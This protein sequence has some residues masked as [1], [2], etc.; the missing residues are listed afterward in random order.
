MD[1]IKQIDFDK[2]KSDLYI[3]SKKPGDFFYPL[4][5][6]GKKK[7]K[8]YFIDHKIPKED[9][10]RVT[11]LVDGDDIVCVLGMQIDDRYKIDAQSKRYLQIEY[12]KM[13][14]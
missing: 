6:Q 10:L 7:L 11:L 1:H 2:I 14:D 8:K 12:T 4:G 13:E 9:R 5:L 3:R